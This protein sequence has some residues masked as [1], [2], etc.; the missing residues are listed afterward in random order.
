MKE[1]DD[2]SRIVFKNTMNESERI[3]VVMTTYNGELYVREQL[4]S[5]LNQS[6][7]P[8]EIVVVDD[9]STDRTFEILQSYAKDYGIIKVYRNE[10][11]I[12]AHQNFRKAF[13]LSTCHLI[14]PSDQDDVWEK[15]K[16]E[17]LLKILVDKGVDLVYSQEYILW[18]NGTMELDV[19]EMPLMKDFIWGNCLKGHTFLFRRELLGVY[20]DVK[21]LSFD[22]ALAIS[23]SI[24]GSYAS[25]KE[26]LSVWRRHKGVMTSAISEN[27][28]LIISEVSRK[29]KLLYTFRHLRKEK[30]LPIQISFTDRS[31]LLRI[32][33]LCKPVAQKSGKNVF[34]SK[35]CANVAKQTRCSMAIASVLNVMVQPREKG[36]R[37]TLA[38]AMWALRQPWIYWYDMHKLKSLE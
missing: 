14:A 34:L 4:D 27:S 17:V 1:V 31:I 29:D 33:P 32:I 2:P 35:I 5:I 20:E 36:I 22:Y 3:S 8:D 15:R 26:P 28:E 18:E 7:L 21:F 9:C 19:H 6:L 30:S 12:G 24:T 16:L 25:S 37:N 23:A 11:N 38:K 10:H 13:G